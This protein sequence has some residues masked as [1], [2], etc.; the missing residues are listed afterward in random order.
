LELSQKKTKKT[1]KMRF[2]KKMGRKRQRNG[3]KNPNA[4]KTE[5]N[6]QRAGGGTGV[7]AEAPERFTMVAPSAGEKGSHDGQENTNL[8][9]TTVPH[10]TEGRR[11]TNPLR[12]KKGQRKRG[13]T[14]GKTSCPKKKKKA[15]NNYR[16]HP[17][18]S[19]T[20][21]GVRP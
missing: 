3:G 10:S 17:R 8:M 18:I 6:V 7:Q 5:N 11:K 2:A 20:G 15:K 16:S 14:P 21:N 13:K 9:E 19:P 1:E 4:Q 12:D